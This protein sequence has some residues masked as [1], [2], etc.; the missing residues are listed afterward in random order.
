M[1]ITANDVTSSLGRTTAPT[2]YLKLTRWG[3]ISN[4]VKNWTGA[5]LYRSAKK[6]ARLCLLM[7]SGH[8]CNL[9]QLTRMG[10]L[11]SKATHWA[12]FC[13]HFCFETSRGDR[14]WVMVVRSKWMAPS[15]T[16]ALLTLYSKLWNLMFFCAN[17]IGLCGTWCPVLDQRICWQCGGHHYQIGLNAVPTVYQRLSSKS[18]PF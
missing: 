16:L 17:M 8:Q 11:L 10:Y 1:L 6:S 18:R 7:S 13:H 5:A 4:W 12:T 3:A 14:N 15:A 9:L 2:K